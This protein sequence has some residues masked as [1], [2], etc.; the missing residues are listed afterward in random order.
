MNSPDKAR[1]AAALAKIEDTDVIELLL[2]AYMKAPSQPS[3]PPAT[4]PVQPELLGHIQ[5]RHQ[6]KL[7]KTRRAGSPWTRGERDQLRRMLTE[8]RPLADICHQL[9]RS[10]R[11]ITS[12]CEKWFPEHSRSIRAQATYVKPSARK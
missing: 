11:S 1:L 9:G 7:V 2:D 4:Q 6:R 12:A 5:D 8:Q 10:E 3:P